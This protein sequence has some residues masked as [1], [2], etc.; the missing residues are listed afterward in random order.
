MGTYFFADDYIRLIQNPK[1]YLT[2]ELEV[3]NARESDHA[4]VLAELNQIDIPVGKLDDVE[5]VMR[6]YPDPFTAKEKWMRRVDRI[7]WD[8]II[9]KFSYMSKCT[10]E[11]IRLFQKIRGVK[12]FCFVPREFEDMEDLYVYPSQIHSMTDLGD[13]VFYWNKHIDVINLINKPVTGIDQLF[14]NY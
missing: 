12:K 1:H 4:D 14:V 5:V 13:D 3:I 11:H 7:N 8:N 9:I 6:H 2:K 10:D